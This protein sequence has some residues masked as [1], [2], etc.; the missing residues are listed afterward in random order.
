MMK[1][2]LSITL[3]GLCVCGTLSACGEPKADPSAPV[4]TAKTWEY[5]QATN[6]IYDCL[7]GDGSVMPLLGFWS[8]P[9]DAAYNGQFFPEM[10]D[11]EYFAAV[12]ESGVNLIVQANDDGKYN[13]VVV[14]KTMS[15]CDDYNLGYYVTNR[16]LIDVG[17]I[18]NKNE[19]LQKTQEY[20]KHK[21]FAG[22]YVKDE[23]MPNAQESTVNASIKTIA[24]ITE[25]LGINAHQY[26]TIFPYE[27]GRF[28]ADPWTLYP[29][30]I[31]DIYEGSGAV[32]VQYD[33]YCLRRSG[34]AYENFY[35]NITMIRKAAKE[36]N[37]SWIPYVSVSGEDNEDKDYL[38][39]SEG[40]LG[41]QVNQYVA[42]GAKGMSYFPMNSPISFAEEVLKGDT[43]AMFDWKG[44]KTEVYYYV[45]EINKQLLAADEYLMNATNH[46]VI[47]HGNMPGEEYLK[48]GEVIEDGK[49]RELKS[50]SGSN[51]FIGCFD[52]YGKTC[53]Y[54]VNGDMEK[55]A[56][57]TLRFDDRYGY[58]LVQRG[59]K[60]NV[61]GSK[62][63]LSLAA[64]E[65]AL[66]AL[67]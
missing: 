53:L 66:I 5:T 7:G 51:A 6:I 62:I 46:G 37:T 22:Y 14:E 61:K 19:L 15:Y 39:P 47:F 26:T 44:N 58:T 41:W 20:A 57:L 63:N 64:G 65:A 34:F 11:D 55:D 3:A 13:D 27:I 2:M 54:V 29:K 52:V 17:L 30:Y 35:T 1:K 8:A 9:G 60:V 21:S 4:Q 36:M 32:N 50:V 10:K 23:P 43:V 59:Q 31:K 56:S 24:E 48:D 45:K 38:M 28:S 16:A 25:E 42:F 18:C 12:Q 67:K 33:I 49:F 40:Q